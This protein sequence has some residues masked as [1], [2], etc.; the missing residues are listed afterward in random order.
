MSVCFLE[1]HEHENSLQAFGFKFITWSVYTHYA[2]DH[3]VPRV[4]EVT[5]VCTCVA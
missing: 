4:F 1:T 3:Y 2:H 5:T